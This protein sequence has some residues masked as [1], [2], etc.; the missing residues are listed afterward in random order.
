MKHAKKFV[1]K[2]KKIAKSHYSLSRRV[3]T[4]YSSTITTITK[5]ITVTQII[6]KRYTTMMVLHN[7]NASKKAFY[8]KKIDIAK[9][10]ALR[11]H[12][13]VALVKKAKKSAVKVLKKKEK[14]HK[15]VIRIRIE[16]KKRL[17]IKKRVQ[18]MRKLRIAK[19]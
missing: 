3:T 6:I 10:K 16:L 13:H 9:K 1:K 12:K 5:V 4:A 17:P 11:L 7:S 18:L 19:K 8:K 14:A 2:V 15:K